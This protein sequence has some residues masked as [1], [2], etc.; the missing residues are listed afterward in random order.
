MNQEIINCEKC[1]LSNN[2]VKVVLPDKGENC[3]GLLVIGEAPGAKE[4]AEGEGFLGAAGARLDEIL[5]S[6][7]IRRD[8][9]SRCN[10]VFCRPPSNRNPT[11]KEIN[12]CSKWLKLIIHQ[13]NPSVILTIGR[14]PSF[15]FY[16]GKKSLL[17]VIELSKELNYNPQLSWLDEKIKVIPSPHTSGLCYNRTAPNKIKWSIII[18]EQIKIASDSLKE[19]KNV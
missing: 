11:K 6:N 4:E 18:N 17:D 16:N 1:D 10:M 3:L 12:E 14:V 9:Y 2:R 13:F 15:S 8:Q 19:I 5:L 7:G